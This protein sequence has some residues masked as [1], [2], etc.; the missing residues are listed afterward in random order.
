[1]GKLINGAWITGENLKAAEALAY[2]KS[3]GKFERGTAGF[4]NRVIEDGSAGPSGE[5]GF[6]A[7]PDRYH[8]F[9]ALN[10]P[11]PHRALIYRMAKSLDK[12]I[13]LSLPAPTRTD[14]GWV[15]SNNVSSG[16]NNKNGSAGRSGEHICHP[17][18]VQQH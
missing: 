13:A 3:D 7:E 11:W 4:R 5:A 12:D 16:L 1:M 10:C 9:A 6:R 15:F 8:L 2:E 14:Q 17:P 18:P